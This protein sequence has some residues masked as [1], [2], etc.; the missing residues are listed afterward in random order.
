MALGVAEYITD[1]IFFLDNIATLYR[2]CRFILTYMVRPKVTRS[3]RT[4]QT[5]LSK[6]AIEKQMRLNGFHLVKVWI[7][8]ASAPCLV[9]MRH[10][11]DA[12]CYYHE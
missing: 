6:E 11:I 9:C 8:T 7:A 1:P 10:M 2:P 4:G 12:Y 3:P 5:Y